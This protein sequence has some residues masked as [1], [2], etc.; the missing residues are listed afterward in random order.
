MN[1]LHFGQRSLSTTSQGPS[2]Q[3]S[4][5]GCT[6]HVPVVVVVVGSSQIW[7]PLFPLTP[8]PSDVLVGVLCR[9]PA[10]ELDWGD[11]EEA[12]ELELSRGQCQFALGLGGVFGWA[13]MLDGMVKDGLNSG[14]RFHSAGEI[15]L[16][17]LQLFYA[18]RLHL[19]PG[20]YVDPWL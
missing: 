8:L 14:L 15:S 6:F 18:D 13:S 3:L 16:P 1:P 4:G 17:D 7:S 10:F 11:S 19:E 20:G 9:S 2:P 12:P 5:I